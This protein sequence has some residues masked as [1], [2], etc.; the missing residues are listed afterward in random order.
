MNALTAFPVHVKG[1]LSRISQEAKNRRS[2]ARKWDEDEPWRLRMA[3]KGFTRD[4]RIE[5]SVP[6]WCPKH[7]HEASPEPIPGGPVQALRDRWAEIVL[8]A[9]RQQAFSHRL[10][11]RDPQPIKDDPFLVCPSNAPSLELTRRHAY[12]RPQPPAALRNPPKRAA[13]ARRG[14]HAP[15][16]P[17]GAMAA[18]WRGGAGGGGG[19]SS[20][21]WTSSSWTSWT[22][23]TW[24]ATWSSQWQ[25]G[26]GRLWPQ[27]GDASIALPDSM[28]FEIYLLAAVIVFALGVVVGAAGPTQ[29]LGFLCGLWPRAPATASPAENAKDKG[30]QHDSFN[31][32]L[33][34]E[35][36]ADP[37]HDKGGGGGRRRG[38]AGA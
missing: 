8:H 37:P 7:P 9:E 14:T 13:G 3:A 11:E 25:P 17:A 22:A 27:A 19:G 5:G 16:P 20:S 35:P 12:E 36:E 31:A 15:A 26:E 2:W 30:E 24:A 38:R 23:W 6:P 21:G 33:T 1:A 4:F 28:G 34:E 18:G 32:L 29:V 10:Q